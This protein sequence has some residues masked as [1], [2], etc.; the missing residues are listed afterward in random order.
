MF[1]QK[2]IHEIYIS[3]RFPY[4]ENKPL[5]SNQLKIVVQSFGVTQPFLSIEVETYLHTSENTIFFQTSNNSNH[6]SLAISTMEGILMWKSCILCTRFYNTLVGRYIISIDGKTHTFKFETSTAH[7]FNFH[8]SSIPLS[9]SLIGCL[10]RIHEAISA[11]VYPVHIVI[12]FSGLVAVILASVS[13]NLVINSFGKDLV[14]IM[15]HSYT[16]LHDT[17][18]R[19]SYTKGVFYAFFEGNSYV[20]NVNR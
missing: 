15:S 9:L 10:L 8:L 12:I 5:L 16:L 2:I 1:V 20:F 17:S 14:E 19:K 11:N 7:L 13:L 6:I 3:F 4:V 18:I